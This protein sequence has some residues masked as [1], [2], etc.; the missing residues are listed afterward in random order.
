MASGTA[1]TRSIQMAAAGPT[2][3][4]NLWR[5]A[6]AAGNA[7]IEGFHSTAGRSASSNRDQ[8]SWRACW[9]RNRVREPT[10]YFMTRTA[11]RFLS[12]I[13]TDAQ[14]GRTRSLRLKEGRFA[15]ADIQRVV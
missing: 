4:G 11:S 13:A 3:N 1:P 9:R 10:T 14:S 5:V 2:G 12:P 7:L 15:I 6:G 8:Y